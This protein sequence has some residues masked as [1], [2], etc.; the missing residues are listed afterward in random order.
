ME[1]RSFADMNYRLM[2]S[3][4]RLPAH[5]DL[6]VGIPRTGL[7]PAG[8]L[9]AALNVPMTDITGLIEGRLFQV[10]QTKKRP[11]I[12]RALGPD[13]TVLI[14]DDSVGSGRSFQRA[15][16][17]VA[18]AGVK[19]RLVWCSVYGEILD[20]PDVDIVLEQ[21]GEP[22][23]FEWYLM[24]DPVLADC[25][26]DIDGVLCGNTGEG[27]DDDGPRYANFLASVG[28]LYSPSQEIG[29][30][31]TG[32]KKKY[33]AETE[34]WLARHGVRYRNLVMFDNDGVNAGHA[35]HKAAF[36]AQVPAVL[37]IE[38]EQDQ[39]EEIARLSAKPVLSIETQNMIA[40]P[41]GLAAVA[42]SLRT[43]P[44][45]VR[46]RRGGL[47]AGH[48]GRLKL[49]LRRMMGDGAYSF[50]KRVGRRT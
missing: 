8:Y 27:E 1:Y 3:R 12:E 7:V 47:W 42:Q 10:G 26:V 39:A 49:R 16:A 2:R 14:I 20:H 24:H 21:T 31:V 6:V 29:W 34:A 18:E 41:A 38:S 4:T 28:P 44:T 11:N 22:C 19:G 45:Y 5:I 15:R 48:A 35:A 40:P 25:C 43:L 13:R 9:A 36:Y 46:N 30:L 23:L 32:R 17:Q 33:R 50:L 37:F